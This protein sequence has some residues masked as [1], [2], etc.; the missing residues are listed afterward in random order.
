MSLYRRGRTYWTDIWVDGIR[1]SK[2]TGTT[3]RREAESI[4]RQFREE[5]NRRRHQIREASPDMTFADLAA[6]SS[7]TDR[8]ALTISTG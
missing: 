5:L 2:S 7:P 6:G 1:H 3:N 4:E 8:L